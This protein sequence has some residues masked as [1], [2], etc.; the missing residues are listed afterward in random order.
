MQN[1]HEHKVPSLLYIFP[2]KA[3]ISS[4]QNIKVFSISTNMRAA[5]VYVGWTVMLE[6]T[7]I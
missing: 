2:S 6:K 1:S 7:L 5:N 4:L 3:G